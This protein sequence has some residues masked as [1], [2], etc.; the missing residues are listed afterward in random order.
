MAA[1]GNIFTMHNLR[2]QHLI[3]VDR[4]R[5]SKRNRELVDHILLM[6]EV[7]CVLWDVSSV[8][9]SCLGLYLDK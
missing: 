1:L 9:L 4:C 2:K 5:M 3:V 8:D 6:C 7:A